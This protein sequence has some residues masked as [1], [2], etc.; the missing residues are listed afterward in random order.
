M[1][2]LSL[3]PRLAA[4]LVPTLLATAAAA[5][6][7]SKTEKTYAYTVTQLEMRTAW[8]DQTKGWPRRCEGWIK[9]GGVIRQ[10]ATAHGGQLDIDW[11]SGAWIGG[12]DDTKT[13][14]TY[15]RTIDY[16]GHLMP[17]VQPCTPCGPL[18]EYGECRPI[19]PDTIV[20]NRCGP[21]DGTFETWMSVQG[22]QLIMY[23]GMGSRELA[24]RCPPVDDVADAGPADADLSPV[25]LAGGGRRLVRLGVGQ[26][27]TL[28]FRAQE[29]SC[30]RIGR[31]GS[32]VCK[33][34]RATVIVRRTS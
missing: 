34:F 12:S 32:H 13:R 23:A 19:V 26:R 18:S 4:I 9:G 15:E 33:R 8:S 30:S 3:L 25:R 24:E 2:T 5:P 31:R 22:S 11:L 17:D 16:R 6:A 20:A 7:A 10:T 28:R 1:G 14:G 27:V 29:G 21:R